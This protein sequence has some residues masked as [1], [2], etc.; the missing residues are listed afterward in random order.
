MIA[1]MITGSDARI[2]I[3]RIRHRPESWRS[4]SM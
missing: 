4:V 1:A 2:V 3:T